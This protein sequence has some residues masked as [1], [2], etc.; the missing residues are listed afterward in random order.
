MSTALSIDGMTCATCVGRVE[1]ALGRVPGV[2]AARVNLATESAA[3][4][5]PGVAPALLIEAVERAGYGAK[6]KS[7]A[8]P[9]ASKADDREALAVFASLAL[10]LPLVLQMASHAAGAPFYLSPWTEFALAAP[11]Q[12]V[13]GWRFYVGAAKA[14]RGA[15]GNM[16]LLVALGTSAAFFYSAWQ[17]IAASGGH[18]YFEAAAVVIAL[19]RLGKWLEAR[20][21]RATTTAVRALIALRPATAHLV[22][23]EAERDV[24]VES[25]KPGDFVA[26][27][28]GET[29]P[30]DGKIAR[31]SSAVDEAMVTGEPIP[32]D[33]AP[34]DTVVAG[35]INRSGRLV[36]ETKAVGGA[37]LLGRIVAAVEEA[38]GSKAPVELLVDKVSAVF[39][40]V[41]VL[42]AL[43]TFAAWWIV[44][45]FEEGIVAA[46]AVL[47]IACPCALGLAT[48]AALI[49][50]VGRA[51]RLGL[52]IKDASALEGLA[53]VDTVAFDKTGTLTE[54]R[55]SVAAIVAKDENALLAAALPVQGASE[56]P[57]ARALVEEGE[58]RGLGHRPAT[59]FEAKIGEG[60]VGLV[61]GKRVFVG[62]RR[63]LEAEGLATE[64]YAADAERLESEGKT[65]VWVGL[66]GEG[67]L[68]LI[69]YADRL[70]P[71]AKRAVD[72]LTSLGV[73]SILLTGDNARTGAIVG[74]A[75]GIE[76]VRSGLMP[77]DKRRILQEL[78]REGRSVAMVGDG[79]ND[80]PALAE[81]QVGIAVGSGADVALE[82]AGVALLRSDPALVA[83]A[84]AL[85]RKTVGR[86]RENLFW[87]FVYNVVGI[88]AAALGLLS[89]MIA[90]AAMA[91]SSVSVIAN[92]LRLKRWRAV[93]TGERP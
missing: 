64:T 51:A 17:V 76:D 18:L 1:K 25:L 78:A 48:P 54:G 67:V 2:V 84:V 52:L 4:D 13:F 3:I 49:V 30:V 69:A 22:E 75:V 7:E 61:E 46:V 87:A 82:T 86:I 15:S 93:A 43:S 38:Q 11:V 53:G 35:T 60:A 85:A 21:K 91:A 63:M 29:V 90:G 37:T 32:V 57:L 24:P 26:L 65:V 19:V 80:A 83:D 50:G 16:D 34:G 23:G 72:V 31:G 73:R 12:F 70:R 66:A 88:P 55:P 71:S 40:P 89:P 39:V 62:R 42:V 5:A 36:I 59:S 10:A 6:L 47:V 33:K 77:G 92:S 81:A 14:L 28:P 58:K 20:A 27:R 8:S 41:V 9:G 44:G 79:I 68:G 45:S 74:R 56:H